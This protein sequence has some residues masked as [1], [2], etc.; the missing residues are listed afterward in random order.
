MKNRDAYIVYLSLEGLF[1]LFFYII[2]T[3]N[4]VYQVEVAKLNPLQLV[5]VGTTLEISAFCFQ[6]PTGIIAD[7]FS[8]RMSIIIGVFL[9]G[10]GF[11][12][13]GSIPRF[14]TIL[15]AQLG[16]GIGSSF[17]SGAEEAWITDEVGEEH[18]GKVFLRGAQFGQCGALIGAAISVGLATFSLNLPI[19]LGGASYLA[20]GIF[21]LIFMP[22]HNFQRAARSERLGWKSIGQTMLT[23]LRLVRGRPILLTILGITLFY[24][25]YS[26][27][28]DRLWTAHLLTDVT[29][30]ALGS[31]KPVVWFGVIR[32]GAMLFSIIAAEIV[33]RHF[34]TNNNLAI[35]RLLL[36]ISIL[37]IASVITFGL[38]GSFM[39][40]IA[41][42]WSYAI[43]RSMFNPL[44]T[45]WLTQNSDANVRATVISFAG[46]I[47]AIGQIVG[48]PVVGVIGTLVSIRAALLA[49]GAL[50]S[51]VI[52]LFARAIRQS[53]EPPKALAE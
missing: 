25:L 40:A 6:V 47:D 45:S 51:P 2:I 38:A 44:H 24:G 48:G 20:L 41:S 39:L 13:E 14:E 50:L 46:Q 16:W 1:S 12:L 43:L 37:Q 52:L 53:K 17:I 33:R 30:P 26:E 8:R 19:I 18:I 42:Y 4:M 36:V 3:V 32:G 34:D 21:L 5:L 7:V 15:L 35:A 29:L 49:A 11:I 22:E 9:T 23:G 31:L 10:F 28:F 27:G